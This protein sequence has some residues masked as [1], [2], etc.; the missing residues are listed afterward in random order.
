VI[1]ITFFMTDCSFY[2]VARVSLQGSE[3]HSVDKAAIGAQHLAVDPAALR[4]SKE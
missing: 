2:L 4:T 1:T 3:L